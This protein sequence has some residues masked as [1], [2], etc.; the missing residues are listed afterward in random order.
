MNRELSGRTANRGLAP[1]DLLGRHP[2]PGQGLDEIMTILYG[3]GKPDNE[4]TAEEV[5][6]RLE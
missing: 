3:E 4:K 1:T 2:G 5:I 6:Q